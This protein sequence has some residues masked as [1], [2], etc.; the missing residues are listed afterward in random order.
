MDAAMM[1]ESM[2]AMWE[3]YNQR[4]IDGWIGFCAEDISVRNL[5]NLRIHGRSEFK[6]YV[7]AWFDCSSDARVTVVRTIVDGRHAAAELRLEGTHDGTGA[8][9]VGGLG[10]PPGLRLGDSCRGRRWS[11]EGFANIQQPG[12]HS[13]AIGHHQSAANATRLRS[14]SFFRLRLRAGWI[15]SSGDQRM[16]RHTVTSQG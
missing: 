12:P 10:G 8:L 3:A 1:R 14:W 2:E 13:G 7:R 4:D 15:S 5:A 6:D 9:W 16:F 11:G